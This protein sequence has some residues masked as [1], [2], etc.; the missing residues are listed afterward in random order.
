[1]RSVTLVIPGLLP[2]PE[3][4]ELPVKSRL[5]YLLTRAD[6]IST[7]SD[8]LLLLAGE[9]GQ[10]SPPGGDWPAAA[11]S[12][13]DDTGRS[14][15]SIC[16][17]IDPVHVAPGREGLVLLDS[18]LFEITGG[19]AA[20]LAAAIQPLLADYTSTIETPHPSRWY[21]QMQAVPDL[22][23]TPLYDVAGRDV[24]PHLP[25]GTARR[26]WHRLLNE[27]Q[28]VL[29]EQP[30]NRARESRGVLTINSVWFWGI[31]ALPITERG[32][33]GIIAADEP[34]ARGLARAHGMTPLSLPDGADELLQT[35]DANQAGLIVID[36]GWRF[37]QYND[38]VGWLDFVDWLEQHWIAPLVHQVNRG[39]LQSLSILTPG[40][41]HH[42]RRR[43]W[44]RFWRRPES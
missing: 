21:M 6:R 13:L 33:A 5:R 27:I 36:S 9:F 32:S 3:G 15:E 7:P 41:G 14:P 29:H 17:R 39:G 40:Q 11:F 24:G 44:W 43:H 20:E 22:H 2:L 4:V 1:M 26:D 38:A 16:M 28:M 10:K 8:Y 30:M 35:G 23:T 31:G 18:S 34:V 12:Y 37:S 25:R 19:E 42:L